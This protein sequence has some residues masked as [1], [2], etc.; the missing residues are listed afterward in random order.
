[1]S[2]ISRGKQVSGLL[3]LATTLS[4]ANSELATSPKTCQDGVVELRSLLDQQLAVDQLWPGSSE[5]RFSVSLTQGDFLQVDVTQKHL[6]LELELR[7]ETCRR[8]TRQDS[9]NSVTD[10]DQLMYIAETQGLHTLTLRR[11]DD[12]S[13][14]GA[15]SFRYLTRRRATKVDQIHTLGASMM[16]EGLYRAVSVRKEDRALAAKD[17]E[18]AAKAWTRLEAKDRLRDLSESLYQLGAYSRN[19]G[20]TESAMRLCNLSAEL[21]SRLGLPKRRALTLELLAHMQQDG[22]NSHQALASW[23]TAR[24]LMA[25]AESPLD[26]ARMLV[27]I[28]QLWER[29]GETYSARSAYDQALAISPDT[30]SGKTIRA[31]AH[32]NLGALYR[33][34][35]DLDRAELE[36][37]KALG[38]QDPSKDPVRPLQ[39]LRN[40]CWCYNFSYKKDEARDCFQNLLHRARAGSHPSLQAAAHNGLG[41]VA[42]EEESFVEARKH[43]ER[44]VSTW[45]KLP[46][47]DGLAAGLLHLGEL[48]MGKGALAAAQ[49]A[50]HE[51]L[52]YS[53]RLGDRQLSAAFEIRIARVEGE[54]G[55][56][57]VALSRS[58]R[59]LGKIEEIRSSAVRTDLRL[60]FTA[61]RRNYYAT[62]IDLLHRAYQFDQE[63]RHLNEAFET[64][65]R[66][67][68]RG[69]LELLQNDEAGLSDATERALMAARKRARQKLN[70]LDRRRRDLLSNRLVATAQDSTRIESLDKDLD[71]AVWQ[72]REVE[73]EIRL[74][75][76]QLRSLVPPN[77]LT[78][79]ELRSH[80]RT[81]ETVIELVLGEQAS[82][83][84]LLESA[85]IEL[86]RL[87]PRHELESR[88]KA[89]R[90][91]LTTRSRGIVGKR[92]AEADRSAKNLA[93]ELAEILLVPVARH[94]EGQRLIIVPDG[95][96]HSLPFAAL[97]LP[98]SPTSPSGRWTN[99]P[100][101]MRHQISV[102]PSLTSI[103][104]LRDLWRSRPPP[105]ET[106]AAWGDPIFEATDPRLRVAK[107]QNLPVAELHEVQTRGLLRRL[108]HSR[109]EVEAIIK[110]AASSKGFLDFDVTAASLE[111][112][113]HFGILHFATHGLVDSE[114][115][116]RSSLVLSLYTSNGAPDPSGLLRLTQILELNLNASLVVLSACRSALG[117]DVLGEGPLGLTRAF[118]R[119]GARRVIA[120][121]WDVDDRATAELMTA[122]YRSYLLEDLTA[123]EALRQAQLEVSRHPATAAPYFWAG[124]HLQG[125]WR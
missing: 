92:R 94:L 71:E 101:V 113:Q 25:Q 43:L 52:R 40:L 72:L 64:A 48:E 104:T 1:M 13:G 69:L 44:A 74:K 75:N 98:A 12:A 45:R 35:G 29:L 59:T 51:G 91:S 122:F 106:L 95:A 14:A 18:K 118:L 11:T 114:H 15:F 99:Q 65:E 85:T 58:R 125:E 60:S 97:P 107:P 110:L 80:L 124:F 62:H 68:A 120:S 7:D 20:W 89:L 56:W 3:L 78:L 9:L 87:P 37:T 66:A 57:K 111:S 88:T 36:Y 23:Q 49:K 55:R 86:H 109:S 50:L 102:Q 76:P 16:A 116:E 100:L 119:A 30:S 39:T 17:F 27:G 54:L 10:T 67:H 34:Q 19:Q 83:L 108:L 2:K 21:L 5:L 32:H 112:S 24:T 84:L 121:Q 81:D 38:F 82:F 31:A 33:D 123:A 26:E 105:R 70:D 73:A 63:T 42:L 96:L 28:G 115:P 103:A 61:L 77:L 93:K 6:D 4:L 53:E 117:R 47:I 22:G 8:V 90:E 79:S 41:R 46:R